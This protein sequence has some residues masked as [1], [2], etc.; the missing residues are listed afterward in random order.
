MRKQRCDGQETRLNLLAAAGEIFARK[1]FR[2]ATIAEICKQAGANTAAISYHFGSKEALYVE[3]WRYAFNQ[4]LKTYPLNGGIPD[5]ATAEDRLRGRILAIMRRI[6]DP[7][8]HEFDIFHKEMASP[9]GLLA[10]AIQ[11]SVEPIFKGL[12]LLVGELLGKAPHEY[13]V[14]L[15]AMSIRAQCF[16]PLMHARRR[17]NVQGLPPTD[18]EP[19]LEDV[20]QL[21]DHV[22]RFSLAGIRAL[23]PQ[24]TQQSDN[25]V[26]S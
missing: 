16:G 5:E 11:E 18:L 4:S 14:Q 6:I 8:S 21:A 22:T 1:G 12:L 13:E 25:E 3:S 23:R 9:T 2:Q 10:K 15:C 26:G 20:E 19:L 17:K 7:K 24:D